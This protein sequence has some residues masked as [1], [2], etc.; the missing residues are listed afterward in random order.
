MIFS[1]IKPTLAL[2]RII[3]RIECVKPLCSHLQPIIFITI[4]PMHPETISSI[5]LC[6]I[7]CTIPAFAKK[8]MRSAM[9]AIPIASIR[10]SLA[11]VQSSL[12]S[13]STS[14]YIP[15]RAPPATAAKLAPRFVGSDI[16]NIAAVA[17]PA[18][19]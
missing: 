8:S 13:I 6:I 2:S 18:A 15:P 1:Q 11:S 4:T 3:A 19:I 10:P 7:L 12:D 9:I 5:G 16:V 17:I 14:G